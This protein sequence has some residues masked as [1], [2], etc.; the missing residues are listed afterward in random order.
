VGARQSWG[1]AVT[2]SDI[3]IVGAGF[4][5]LGAAIQLKRRG[6]HDFVVFEKAE[7]IG[8]TWRDNSYPGCACDVPSHLYSFS[9]A[10]NP[11]WSDTYSGQAEIWDYLRGCVDRFGL[12]RHLRLGCRVENAVWDPTASRWRLA[13]ATGEHVA[14]VLVLATGPLHEASIPDI[15]GLDTF[16]GAVFHSARWDH[17]HDLSGRTVAV[18]GTGASAVQ[19][20]P[21]IQPRV[22]HLTL[23]QRTPA[24]VIPGRSRAITEVERAIYRRVP[25]AQRLNR[26]LIYWLREAF[27]YGF[28]HPG[29]NRFLQRVAEAHLRRQVRDPRLRAKLTPQFVMGCKR[30]LISNEYFPALGRENVTVETDP[31]TEVRPDGVVTRDGLHPVDTIIFG[32]GFHVTDVP[33]MR[34]VYG[35][36]GRTL[37]EAWSPTMSA[38]LGTTVTGFPNLFVLLGPNTGLGHNS[39][40]FM[41]EAQ[42]RHLLDVLGHQRRH[43]LVATEPTAAAQQRWTG[44]VDRRMA[45]TVWVSGGCTSW[46]LDATGRNSTLWP[47]YATGF[48]LR[49][50]RFRAD[51][52]A[53]PSPTHPRVEVPT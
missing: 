3:A 30:I 34:H 35:R 27:G 1:P 43:G 32:T 18:V 42:L 6:H 7:E 33:V 13:T 38:Y 53:V 22:A 28:L 11:Q 52:Y 47:G 49:L 20:V 25:G 10:L 15:P 24:W 37:A 14:R 5:G 17:G 40:V 46:Y 29:V 8:G 41:I 12:G 50:G 44:L 23:F 26:T 48:R 45:G 39:V 21:A 2:E 51:D 31:I 9:F 4:G 19:F 36:D 16:A